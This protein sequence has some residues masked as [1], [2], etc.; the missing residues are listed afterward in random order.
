MPLCSGSQSLACSGCKWGFPKL[1]LAQSWRWFPLLQY[2]ADF[3]SRAVACVQGA[4]RAP[5]GMQAED[6]AVPCS[7]LCSGFGLGTECEVM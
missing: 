7:W 4:F 2:K 1:R 3:V 5:I 6:S